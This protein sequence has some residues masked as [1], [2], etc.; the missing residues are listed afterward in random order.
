[1]KSYWTQI[2]LNLSPE[3]QIWSILLQ[4]FVSDSNFLQSLNRKE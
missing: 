4:L 2:I 3:L 1:M